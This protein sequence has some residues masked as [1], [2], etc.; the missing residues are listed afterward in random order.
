MNAGTNGATNIALKE[1]AVVCDAL[2]AGRQ[3]LL[4]RKGGI[5]E[6][7]QQFKIEHDAFFLYPN[8]EHQ[9][10]AQVKAE[11]DAALDAPPPA[12]TETG[13]VR[14]PGYCWVTDVV[15]V[16][17][18]ERL[19]AL[20]P[21]TCWTQALFDVRIAYKPERP[22]YVV[23]VRAYALPRPIET[24]YHKTYAGCRSWVPFK[25]AYTPRDA[26]PALDDASF[27]AARGAV[28]RALG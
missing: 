13:V 4:I 22:N 17:E 24:P 16:T 14:V 7:R 25:E 5:H 3:V 15:E 6:P 1:W 20:E 27:E 11:Y 18:P 19:R 26:V 12:P 9:T 8:A 10:R 28:L 23:V 21:L 2:L